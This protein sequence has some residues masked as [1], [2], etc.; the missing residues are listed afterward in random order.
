MLR[1][2]QGP[3]SEVLLKVLSVLELRVLGVFF[4]GLFPTAEVVLLGFRGLGFRFTVRV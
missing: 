1:T 3:A 4:Q 2:W